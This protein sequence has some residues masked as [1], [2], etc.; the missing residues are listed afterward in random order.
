MWSLAHWRSHQSFS[1]PFFNFYWLL[2]KGTVL[3]DSFLLWMGHGFHIFFVTLLLEGVSFTNNCKFTMRLTISRQNCWEDMGRF[4][5]N[6]V[7]FFRRFPS[8][9]IYPS[10]VLN[11]TGSARNHLSSHSAGTLLHWC[12]DSLLGNQQV[13]AHYSIDVLIAYWVTS[14]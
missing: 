5:V 10:L 7:F 8:A 14:R 13:K 1:K 6:F 3:R 11:G 4:E 12:S 9:V 2:M